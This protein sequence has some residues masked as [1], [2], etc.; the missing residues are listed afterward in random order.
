MLEDAIERGW[1]AYGIDLNISA[2][3]NGRDRGLQIYD[4]KLEELSS[5]TF[6]KIDVVTMYDVLE[7]FYNPKDMIKA[8]SRLLVEDGLLVI[9]VP[10]W[11]SLARMVLGSETFWIWGI[12]HLS[13]FSIETL[14]RMVSEQGFQLLHYET[15]G[16][17]V[18][19][20]IWSYENEKGLD[21]TIL[22]NNIDSFQYCC[23]EAGLGALLRLFVRK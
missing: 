13:Y 17:D 10:N 12:F 23:A 1:E 4:Y 11:N 3:K 18:A 8:G 6:G 14:S 2:V 16:M 21:T 7:H 22:K 5:N 19:D 20:I 15:Q 9:Y